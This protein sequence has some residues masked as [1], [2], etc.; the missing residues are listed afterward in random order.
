MIND[1]DK[2]ITIRRGQI[3]KVWYFNTCEQGDANK[4]HVRIIKKKINRH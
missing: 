1:Q 3:D 4:Y 2:K